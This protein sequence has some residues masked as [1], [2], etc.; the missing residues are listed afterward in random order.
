MVRWYDP[1]GIIGATLHRT[2]IFHLF[3][4]HQPLD[5]LSRKR[6]KSQISSEWIRYKFSIVLS[7][8]AHP[9]LFARKDMDIILHMWKSKDIAFYEKGKGGIDSISGNLIHH[10]NISDLPIF[11]F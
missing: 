11:V 8:M 4:L 3:F 9:I 1:W 7:C 5:I 10:G 2:S 6:I